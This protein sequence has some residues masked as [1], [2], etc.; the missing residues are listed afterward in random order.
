MRNQITKFGAVII[1]TLANLLICSSI[2]AQ[3]PQAINFQAIARD[4][5]SNP[6]ENTNIQIRLSVLDG[7]TEGT[8]VYQE[9][10][11]LETNTYGSFSFQIGVDPDFT[12]IGTFEEIDWATGDKFLQIDYDPSNTFTFSLTLGTIEFVSIPYAFA[13][14][15]VVFI[16][17]TDA[18]DGDVLVYNEA[19]GKFEPGTVT[20][21]SVTWENVQD[22]PDF[23][24]WD[25]DA[26]DDFSGDYNDLI[27]QPTIPESADG[28]ETTIIAGDNITVSGSGTIADPYI[29][30]TVTTAAPGLN[31]PVADILTASDI[32]SFA[33][34][35]NG[36]VNANGLST[37]VVFEWGTTTAYDNTTNAIPYTVT[38]T[39]ITAVSKALTGLQSNTTYHYR[40]KATNAVDITYSND[41]SFTTSLSAP[42]LTTTAISSILAFTASSGGNIT[43][44]GGSP[45]TT[46]GV[47]WST[48]PNPTTANTH[49][50]SGDGTGTFTVNMTGLTHNT[51]YYVR[52][53]ATNA[54]GTTY[55]NELN[56]T[57]QSGVVSLTTNTISTITGI[58]AVCGGNITAD[59][60]SL[61]T[62]RGVC[63]STTTGPTTTNSSTNDGT[64]NGAFTSNLSGLALGTTYYIRAYAT[65]AVGT[66]YGNERSFTTIALPTLTTSDANDIKGNSSKAGGV[67]TNNG[68]STVTAQG[69]CW[70]TTANPTTANNIT[71]SFTAVMTGLSPNTTYYVRAYATNIAGTGYGNEI[72]FNSG[73]LIG[74]SFA[75]GLVF[76]NDGAGHGLVSAE[77]DQSTGAE[78]GCDGTAI[79]GTSS[80]INTGAA[81]TNAIV[82][83]CT[84]A[85]IAA[86][87]CYDL[88][89]NTYTDWYLP[90]IDELNLMYVNLHTQS[91]GSFTAT[92]Y[93]SSSEYS[94]YESDYAWLQDFSNGNQN[95][96]NKNYTYYVRAV[97]AF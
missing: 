51:T 10:R 54:V 85:G 34:T 50:A 29:V 43:Y 31:P 46:R 48:S 56:F 76:Y 12:T 68:G 61:V 86:K 15:T 66:T 78:W 64:G 82:A 92:Y 90:S 19:T 79:G 60:G 49:V 23:A 62:A 25:T 18:V 14:E 55:G 69:L 26:T 2:F 74:S 21:G 73:R 35:L 59:G 3:V 96:D 91:L 89:L 22:K 93:W 11:A 8:I 41:M 16:D 32:A 83:G 24:N 67:V 63:W 13:A 81:N 52:A 80:A 42:Q 7:S 33:V 27:N 58:T 53:Y 71:S 88:D 36:N 87:L 5:D 57:T 20:A 6:M 30:N 65:N 45:V 37:T 95:L 75:G 38:G 47:C 70:S 97:R 77:T 94:G 17:A 84:T 40:I 28:S 9:L 4:G 72:S 44:D 39:S 1:I